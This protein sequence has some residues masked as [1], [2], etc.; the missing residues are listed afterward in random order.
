MK[1][2][3]AV[4]AL[5]GSI[6]AFTPAQAHE[7]ECMSF[8]DF[9]R[10]VVTPGKFQPPVFE[11]ISSKDEKGI[12]NQSIDMLVS[13]STGMVLLVEVN[14]TGQKLSAC[15]IKKFMRLR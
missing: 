13:P 14:R 3:L 4:L 1:K 8:G 11:I 7:R 10:N 6:F 5:I 9:I 15:V 12:P 2:Y